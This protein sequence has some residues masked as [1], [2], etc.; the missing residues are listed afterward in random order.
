MGPGRESRGRAV[1]SARLD[2]HGIR[3]GLHD[4]R[5]D[6]AAA[7]AKGVLG[8]RPADG[9]D[10]GSGERSFQDDSFEVLGISSNLFRKSYTSEHVILNVGFA[11]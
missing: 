1:R 2:P 3:S 6:G 8:R 4:L 11:E 10:T 7:M 5:G 9:W